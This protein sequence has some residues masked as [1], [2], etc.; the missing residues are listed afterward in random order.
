[1]PYYWGNDTGTTNGTFTTWGSSTTTAST[2]YVMPPYVP[3]PETAAER[4]ERV[5]REE[6][7]ARERL[8]AK[9]RAEALL[10]TVLGPGYA[11]YQHSG[12]VEVDSQQYP[13]RRYRIEPDQLIAV[14]EGERVL[15]R[16]CIH[17]RE[18]L[19]VAD[20]IVAKL[21]LCQHD[22]ARLLRIAIPHG[23]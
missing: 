3:A 9:E 2:T 21:L 12:H 10:Q 8:E 20:E 6:A 19:P 1:M 23:A 15:N 22:E 4:R 16:L 14:M 18:E 7:A 17:A 5:R 13:G 11:D